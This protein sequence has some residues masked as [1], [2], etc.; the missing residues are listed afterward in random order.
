MVQFFFKNKNFE[1]IKI[2]EIYVLKEL[3]G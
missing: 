3:Y 1:I 2:P